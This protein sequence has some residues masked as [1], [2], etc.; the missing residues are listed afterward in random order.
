MS[1]PTRMMS[2]SEKRPPASRTTRFRSRRR[3]R[4]RSSA[5]RIR[6][7]PCR[8]ARSRTGRALPTA[9][10]RDV[11]R[12][13]R[14]AQR[15]HRR[16]GEQPPD[17]LGK[18]GANGGTAH[19]G[20]LAHV[21]ILEIRIAP[22]T[23]Q[24]AFVA[25]GS[26]VRAPEQ[27]APT[28][29]NTELVREQLGPRSGRHRRD[30]R[31]RRAR[32]ARAC[33]GIGERLLAVPSANSAARTSGMLTAPLAIVA[34]RTASTNARPTLTMTTMRLR[35]NRSAATPPNRP[36]SSTGR[37]SLRTA[38]ETRNGSRVRD[39]TRSGPAEGR[40]RRRCC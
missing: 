5:G 20:R 12:R 37:N 28:G 27:T 8:A 6:P 22:R 9:T 38:S 4:L 14:Q 26:P 7:R 3:S 36:N 19:P 16:V 17:P 1:S 25:S 10:E 11:E 2:A 32:E 23:K 31:A 15:P 21:T 35:S 39:A 30:R 29:G 34:T 40:H 24:I 13:G 33:C 18:L